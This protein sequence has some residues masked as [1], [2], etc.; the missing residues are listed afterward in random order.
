MIKDKTQNQESGDNS[1]NYQAETINQYGLS[2]RDAKEIALDVFQQNFLI[3]SEQAKQIARE[4]VEEITNDFLNEIKEKNSN[5]LNSVQEPGMQNALYSAQKSYAVSGDKDTAKLLVD[6]LVERAEQKERNLIQ[7]VLDE[8]L[9]V[10]SKLT[11]NQLDALT[12][13][14]LIKQ[15]R[16]QNVNNLES[17]NEILEFNLKP[18]IENLR[19]D[20]SDYSHLEYCNCG[21]VTVLTTSIE[22]KFLKTYKGLFCKGV[23]REEFEEQYKT[24]LDYPDL[25]TP[26]LHDNEKIQVN[27]LNDEALKDLIDKIKLPEESAYKLKTFFNSNSMSEVEVKAYLLNQGK[28]ME[29]LFD[30]WENSGL[31]LMS[32]TSV[33]IAIAQ[34]NYKRKTGNSVDLSIWIK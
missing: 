33:G 5:L 4:R 24:L 28:Y 18:F 2:Y 7:I 9:E 23:F 6:I 30:V 26:C 10:V 32:I 11:V 34:A 31:K 17:F 21:S 27:A 16:F 19:K 3:L 22:S 1:A 13:I 12:I 25:T 8:S 15:T 20:D 29:K 14:F